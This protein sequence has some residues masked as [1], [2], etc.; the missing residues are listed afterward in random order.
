MLA[1]SQIL[2]II[3]LFC[4]F[5][6]YEKYRYCKKKEEKQWIFKDDCL[7]NIEEWVEN[8]TKIITFSQSNSNKTY[9]NEII[10]E[11]DFWKTLKISESKFRRFA[12]PGD[13]ILFK[14]KTIMNKVQRFITSSNFDHVG[15]LLRDRKGCLQVMEATGTEGVTC[16][17]WANFMTKGWSREYDLIVY[18]HLNCQR[19]KET[20][21]KLFKFSKVF[22]LYFPL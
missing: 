16:T 10:K 15:L 18:R 21:E 5:R 19:N 1:F 13:L 9:S 2:Q 11:I 6:N 7:K 14:G 17:Y 8:I 20:M 22:F 3:H 12:A 4:I